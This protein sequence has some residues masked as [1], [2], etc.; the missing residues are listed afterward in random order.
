MTAQRWIQ[1]QPRECFEDWVPPK[2]HG[3]PHFVTLATKTSVSW[4]WTAILFPPVKHQLTP[5]R[6]HAQAS[7]PFPADL[8]PPGLLQERGSTRDRCSSIQSFTPH[9]QNRKT[10]LLKFSQKASLKRQGIRKQSMRTA[11]KQQFTQQG[12]LDK[13]LTDDFSLTFVI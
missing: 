11:A 3:F 6:S 5:K 9:R 7:T 4:P 1:K 12:C 2:G 8:T 13:N 10:C